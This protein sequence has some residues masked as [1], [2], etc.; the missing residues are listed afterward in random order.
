MTEA[1][2]VSVITSCTGRKFALSGG[3]KVAAER[4]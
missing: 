2:R 1:L 3:E 4:L